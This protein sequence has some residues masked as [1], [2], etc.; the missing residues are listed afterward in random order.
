MTR[1]ESVP[2]GGL[3]P[4]MNLN[5]GR[6]GTFEHLLQLHPDPFTTYFDSKGLQDGGVIHDTLRGRVDVKL[7]TT[8]EA[9][10]AENAKRVIGKGLQRVQRGADH[11][12]GHVGQATSKV[13]DA[14]SVQVE[15]EGVDGGVAAQCVLLGRTKL[16][17]GVTT[18][19]GVCLPA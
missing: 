14:A 17:C 11:A 1:S 12:G 13:F 10:E 8:G 9:N 5:L 15:E 4:K 6:T 19:V 3:G 16:H 18:V 2:T 7:Q